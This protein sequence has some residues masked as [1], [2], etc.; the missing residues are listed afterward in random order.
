MKT[1]EI[2]FVQP[3]IRLGMAVP[4][5][6]ELKGKGREQG[7]FFD[8][9]GAELPQDLSIAQAIKAVGLSKFELPKIH[10]YNKSDVRTINGKQYLIVTIEPLKDYV[11]VP[12]DMKSLVTPLP[13]GKTFRYPGLI[14][15]INIDT[16]EVEAFTYVEAFDQIKSQS[17][18]FSEETRVKTNEAIKKFNERIDKID[19]ATA[20]LANLPLQLMSAKDKVDERINELNSM[21]QNLTQKAKETSAKPEVLVDWEKHIEQQ[22]GS[23]TLEEKELT[24]HILAKYQYNFGQL[25]K[26]LETGKLII[27][28]NITNPEAYKQKLLSI[29]KIVEEKM[30]VEKERE[31][32]L[33]EEKKLKPKFDLSNQPDIK[34]MQLLEQGQVPVSHKSK[35]YFS[36][37]ST[38][39]SIQHAIAG[40]Q[41]DKKDL[42]QISSQLGSIGQEIGGLEEGQRSYNYLKTP[43][44]QKTVEQLK[45]LCNEGLKKFTER[46]SQDIVDDQG[47]LDARKFSRTGDM[48][49]AGL[50]VGFTKIYQVIATIF[51][52][53]LLPPPIMPK[54]PAIS[55]PQVKEPTNI[56]PVTPIPSPSTLI[57]K[58]V[59]ASSNKAIIKISK[60]EWDELGK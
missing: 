38:E 10:Y 32:Q 31:K 9:S 4:A 8:P 7:V 57:G 48:G 41:E 13:D 35:G 14:R 42:S 44:G 1:I 16:G 15:A 23:G 43:I 34:E 18:K 60:T 53:A 51:K 25:K 6:P 5:T 30:K 49:N 55:I 20:S 58:P 27:P 28:S 3:S 12:K 59:K 37:L 21:I 33:E 47:R 24:D 2:K 29:V 26:D 22:I 54:S 39:Q 50:I 52:K 56:P 40:C 45:A 46:Y 36:H 11:K 19:L 17:E